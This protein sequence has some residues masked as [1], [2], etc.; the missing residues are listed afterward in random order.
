MKAYDEKAF[1]AFKVIKHGIKSTYIY[2][3]KVM[4]SLSNIA[5]AYSIGMD[6]YLILLDII[7]SLN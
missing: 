2:L 6:S 1:T 5:P 4:L 7:A 3:Y